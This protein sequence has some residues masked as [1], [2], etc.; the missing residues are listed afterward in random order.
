MSGNIRL[1]VLFIF[2]LFCV[3]VFSCRKKRLPGL[4]APKSYTLKMAG[5][6]LFAG[7]DT[8]GFAPIVGR[9]DTQKM[10]IE[11]LND[12]TL[13]IMSD[14]IHYV[15]YNETAKS[16]FFKRVAHPDSVAI[17]YFFQEDSITYFIYSRVSLCCFNKKVLHTIDR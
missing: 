8:L 6:R 17:T 15:S 12:S 16:L 5:S 7:T 2:I 10:N 4:P 14:T 1:L 3:F 9:A 13:K 11:V